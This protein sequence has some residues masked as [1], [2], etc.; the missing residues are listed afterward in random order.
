MTVP[1]APFAIHFVDL[2]SSTK[3]RITYWSPRPVPLSPLPM[4]VAPHPRPLSLP[5]VSVTIWSATT[6][7]E[8]LE[9][10]PGLDSTPCVTSIKNNRTRMP[11]ERYFVFSFSLWTAEI[12]RTG[13]LAEVPIR[14]RHCSV[15]IPFSTVAKIRFCHIDANLTTYGMGAL[16]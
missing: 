13:W 11:K 3:S 10:G 4:P 12:H 2:T 8:L 6:C 15:L 16:P 1:F 5:Y 9:S 14:W 7:S